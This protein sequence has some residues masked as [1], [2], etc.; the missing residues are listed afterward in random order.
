MLIDATRL[1]LVRVFAASLREFCHAGC[2]R[3]HGCD[4][5]P[6]QYLP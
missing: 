2:P 6:Y 4:C 3:W 1:D 5:P